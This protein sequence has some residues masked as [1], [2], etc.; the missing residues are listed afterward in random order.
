M[1]R[2]RAP[3]RLQQ[4]AMLG[5]HFLALSTSVHSKVKKMLGCSLQR[6]RGDEVL[7]AESFLPVAVPA[8]SA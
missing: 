3:C 8:H 5:V 2:V 4:P 6:H 1:F 7:G